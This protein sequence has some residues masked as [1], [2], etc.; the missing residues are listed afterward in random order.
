MLHKIIALAVCLLFISQLT[1]ASADA[2]ESFFTKFRALDANKN[3]A[4]DDTKSKETYPS[5]AN[6]DVSSSFIDAELLD[7][8]W[9]GDDAKSV[10]VL[11]SKGTVYQTPDQGK[12][13][14]KLRETFQRTGKREISSE[15][16]VMNLILHN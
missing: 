7:I 1:I 13:W 11:T 14:N 16:D 2:Y 9:C 3:S 15:E 6:V 5:A 8:L 10:L 12:T 4:S